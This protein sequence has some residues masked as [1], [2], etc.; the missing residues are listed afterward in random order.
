MSAHN[1]LVSAH[2]H[3]LVSAHQQIVS[4][5]DLGH[6]ESHN[7]NQEEEVIFRVCLFVF[8]CLK[9][10][11]AKGNKSGKGAGGRQEAME[12]KGHVYTKRELSVFMIHIIERF[13][14]Y[15]S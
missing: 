12:S 9:G 1:Q 3:Q 7:N 8:K 11:S 5:V 14:D 6:M 2:N 10:L 13:C 15:I 4:T